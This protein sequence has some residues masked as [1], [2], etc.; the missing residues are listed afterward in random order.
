MRAWA[1]WL[2][3]LYPPPWRERYA[4]EM[5]ALLALHHVTGR[6]LLDLLR[7]A[8]D[9]WR[10][11]Q[12]LLGGTTMT[13]RLVHGE[14]AIF[15]AFVLFGLGW[16]PVLQVRDPIA[17]WE[18]VAQAHPA[19]RAAYNMVQLAGLVALLAV[20]AGGLPVGFVALRQAFHARRRD[21]LRLWATPP[22]AVAA[23]TVYCLLASHGWASRHWPAP[24]APL[25]TLAVLLQLGLAL[26][27]LLMISVCS[28]A[29]ALAVARAG[30]SARVL[31]FAL[32]PAVV[33]ALAIVVGLVATLALGGLLAADA[34]GLLSF[35]TLW[36]VLAVIVLL[37]AVAVILAATGLAHGLRAVCDPA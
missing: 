18:P 26:G 36:P 16:L 30:L 10:R 29:V 17:A 8:G 37:M 12:F 28:A 35:S 3:R 23:F 15:S 7:G 13:R 9:A 2:L 20:L 32:T 5:L 25:T 14:L 33:A 22:L 11:Q 1:G 19:M 31:R 27:F 34:P 4:E 24:D 21:L 6:T